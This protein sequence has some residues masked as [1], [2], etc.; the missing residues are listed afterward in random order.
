M[1]GGGM[2]ARFDARFRA[3][4]VCVCVGQKDSRRK[5]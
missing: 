3:C 4:V 1:R 2:L 5:T